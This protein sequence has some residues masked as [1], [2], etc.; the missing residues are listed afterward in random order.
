MKKIFI[1]LTLLLTFCGLEACKQ[2]GNVAADSET[3]TTEAE[4]QEVETDEPETLEPE[5]L[6][7]SKYWEKFQE[8][9]KEGDLDD[10]DNPL[11]KY[12]LIDI[13][14]DGID[15][16]WVRSENDEDGAVFCFDDE[17]EPHLIMAETEGK[18]I[19]FGKGW[20]Y[21]GY[22]AGGPSYFNNYVVLKNSRI[23]FD[24]TDFQ[25][26]ENHEYYMGD[27]EIDE[28]E[29]KELKKHIKGEGNALNPEWHQYVSK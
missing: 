11:T 15:E 1:Y 9:Y 13:D 26:E 10:L 3:E 17:D 7:V 14:E 12:A 20:V 21:N 27:T 28:A 24:F 29:F 2:S 19:S 16:V 6:D 4:A 8:L 22:P 18:R 25:I 23:E 5:T